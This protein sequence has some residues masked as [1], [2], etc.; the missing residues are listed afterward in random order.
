MSKARDL[1]DLLDSTG[2]VKTDALDNAQA[3]LQTGD[4]TSDLIADDAITSDLIADN[5]ITSDLIADN[6]VGASELNLSGDGTSGQFLSSDGDGSFSWATPS[7]GL[8]MVVHATSGSGSFTPANN[9][10]YVT[11]AGGGGAGGHRYNNDV[12]GYYDGGGGGAACIREK[13]SVTAGSTY[14]YSVGAGGSASVK[15][16]TPGNGGATTISGSGVS[17][18]LG[19]GVHGMQNNDNTRGGNASGFPIH[20][21]FVNGNQDGALGGGG[22]LM[23]NSANNE[24]GYGN[25]HGAG[26]PVRICNT[27]NEACNNVVNNAGRSGLLIIEE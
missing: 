27:S 6:A 14:N 2:D 17:L 11:A 1:A 20:N 12:V 19:G 3:S 8:S 16:A 5:A 13:I 18:S 22:G 10:I 4:I 25:G 23:G 26:A 21:S 7:G 9:T 15:F 24:N